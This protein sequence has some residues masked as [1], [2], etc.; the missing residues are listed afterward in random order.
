MTTKNAR[1]PIALATLDPESIPQPSQIIVL[2][3]STAELHPLVLQS[4][5]IRAAR[6]ARCGLIIGDN[7]LNGYQLARLARVNGF[8]P[9]Q[10]FARIEF[11]R[12]FTCHQLHHCIAQLPLDQRSTWRALYILGLLDSFYDE[13]IHLTIALQLLDDILTRLRVN[14]TQGLPVL[15]TL[16]PPPRGTPR[17]HLNARV[18][19][20]ADAHGQPAAATIERF[21][22][23]PIGFC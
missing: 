2:Y 14:A 4:L 13:D 17:A 15:I 23:P 11:S 22:T 9:A 8:D 21:P 20:V 3:G 12:P 18:I 10:L 5:F 1:S 19:R 16:A 7:H 6:A